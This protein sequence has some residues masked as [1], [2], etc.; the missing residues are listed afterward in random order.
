MRPA[1]RRT[2]PYGRGVI[3]VL[4]SGS[5][6]LKY[7]LIA[8]AGSAASD[9]APRPSHG[10]GPDQGRG[11]IVERIG[12]PDGVA[13]HRAA[14]ELAARDI[15][16]TSAPLRAVG[17]RVVH[18]GPRFRAPTVIDDEVQAAI[19]ALAE[20]APLHNPGNLAGIEVARRLRPDVPHVAVF[21]TA[22]HADLPE[23]A[24]TYPIDADVARRHGIRRYGFHGTSHRYAA[25]RVA[26]LLGRDAGEVNTIVLHLG[27]GASAAAVRGGRSVDTSMGFTPLEG[28]VMG[29]R[30]GDLD[31]GVLIHLLRQPGID[32][33]ALDRLLHHESGLRG[34]CGD[35]DMRAVLALRAKGDDRAALAFDVYCYRIRKYVGAYHAVLGRLDALV[36][37]GGVGEHA[38]AVRAACLDGLG[39]W[40][41]EVDPRRNEPPDTGPRVV[42]PEGAPVAVCVIPADEELAIAEETAQLLDKS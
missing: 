31:P 3:L 16:L 42:S 30:P 6:S 35:G 12:E 18:G 33:E 34:L 26:R 29:T 8:M 38:P 41:I 10:V 1:R 24:A 4:N 19:G 22:F 5:S 9:A 17:H 32:T 14:L 37:T 39:P 21:D 15:G 28:L 23:A 25:L 20:L 2:T 27:N 13:D 40:G 7:R 36:F 11:G